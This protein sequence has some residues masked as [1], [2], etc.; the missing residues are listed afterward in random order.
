MKKTAAT[1]K[2]KRRCH[3]QLFLGRA[4]YSSVT[5]VCT[6]RAFFIFIF[7][8][9]LRTRLPFSLSV[10]FH[11]AC[12]ACHC[13]FFFWDGRPSPTQQ[14]LLE[15]S[16]PMP[17]KKTRAEIFFCSADYMR[18]CWLVIWA[19]IVEKCKRGRMLFSLLCCVRGLASPRLSV[20]W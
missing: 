2:G 15:K 6:T 18:D 8:L 3:S 12:L 17:K 7:I 1:Q 16:P 14:V 13:F 20:C 10:R 19:A 5:N 11:S 4:S 9:F